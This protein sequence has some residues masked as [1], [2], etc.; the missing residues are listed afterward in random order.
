MP[1]V[2]LRRAEQRL[3]LHTPH[4]NKKHPPMPAGTLRRGFREPSSDGTPDDKHCSVARPDRFSQISSVFSSS[5]ISP[6]RSGKSG[7]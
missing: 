4:R 6:L 1:S 2:R 5:R 3:T 7:Q